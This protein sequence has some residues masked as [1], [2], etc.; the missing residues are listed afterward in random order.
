MR[1]VTAVFS[2]SA[3]ARVHR[4]VAS[5]NIAEEWSDDLRYA[6][7]VRSDSEQRT[8]ERLSRGGVVNIVGVDSAALEPGDIIVPM[9]GKS[10][11]TVLHRESDRHHSLLLTNR[12][13]SYCLMCSQPPTRHDDS[14][15]VQEA[16]EVVRHMRRSPETI[17]LSGGEP[18]LLKEGLRQIL[19]AISRKHPATRIDVL[20]NGRLFSDA[21]VASTV[22]DGATQRIAW[23]V[24]LYGHADF[25]HDFVVQA[26]GAFEETVAGLLALQARR[27]VIQLRI[28]LIEPVLKVLRPLCEFIGK[29]LPFV[30]EVALM[31]CEP[32]GFA[33]ANRDQCEVDLADWIETLDGAV[34]ALRRHAV[35]FLFMNIPLCALPARMRSSACMSISDWKNVYAD[36]CTRCAARAQCSGLFAWHVQGWKPTR[37]RAIEEEPV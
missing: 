25:V 10:E 11:A 20:T 23:L 37:I 1:R 7:L 36:E 30:R 19:E 35:P 31:G 9:P 28:V 26:P 33:L 29:N 2:S 5:D 34:R 6:L 14:W 3:E 24:P 8:V 17:G 16:L 27:Q 22:L 21:A 13:N 12:C 32:V 15:L 18:L 4:V